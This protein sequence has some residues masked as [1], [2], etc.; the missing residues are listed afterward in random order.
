LRDDSVESIEL[1]H[2]IGKDMIAQ[3]IHEA[4]FTRRDHIYSEAIKM[5]YEQEEEE[6][7]AVEL[8]TAELSGRPD[9]TR[10]Y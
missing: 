3:F 7:V 4:V 1:N 5:T 10:S 2:S 6:H 9:S 8:L